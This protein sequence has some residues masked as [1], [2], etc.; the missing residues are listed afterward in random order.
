MKEMPNYYAIIPADVRYNKNLKANENLLYGEITSLA[1]KEG[2]CWAT[3]K[4]FAELYGVSE[5][6]ISNWISSLVKQNYI[7][8]EINKDP[9]TKQVKQRKL[10]ITQ[11]HLKK[12]LIGIKENFDNPIKEN[13]DTPIKEN[14]KENTTSINTKKESNIYSLVIDHLNKKA[15][16]NYKSTTNKTKSLIN[17]RI[18]EGFTVDDFKRVIDIKARDWINDKKMRKYLRP[19]TLFGTKFEGYLN[20]ENKKDDE[21]NWEDIDLGI[22]LS[23]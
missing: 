11:S 1:N 6:S 5:V 4:Y 8:R 10:Y 23:N 13:F 17:A 18:N 19:E 2:F 3:N 7:H 21:L 20:E 9:R 14:F 12:T 16:T 22:T 15:K